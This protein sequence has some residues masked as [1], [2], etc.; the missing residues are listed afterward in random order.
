MNKIS[1]AFAD[2]F[3]KFD[4]IDW[5]KRDQEV[6]ELIKATGQAEAKRR[7]DEENALLAEKGYPLR[8]LIAARSPN[9]SYALDRVDAWA[10]SNKTV[11]VLSGQPGCGKTVA[12]VTW[13]LSQRPRPLFLRAATFATASR[14]DSAKRDEWIKAGSLILDDLGAEFQDAKG[15]FSVDLDELI[16]TYYGNM[17]RL[18]I[19]TNSGPAEFK[20]RYGERVADRIREAGEFVVTR[21]ESLRGQR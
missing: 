8:A 2:V 18:V 12:A 16:D 3:A 7:A 5:D 13:A 10:K 6:S 21:G 17:K 20:Q 14:Y 19:T 4:G 9:P 15:S 1:D 11:I